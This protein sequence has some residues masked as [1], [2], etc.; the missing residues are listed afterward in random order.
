MGLHECP[1]CHFK[2]EDEQSLVLHLEGGCSSRN[3]AMARHPS[4]LGKRVP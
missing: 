4:V 2:F 1:I 3:A